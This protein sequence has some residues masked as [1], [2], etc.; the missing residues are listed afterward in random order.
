MHTMKK[1]FTLVELLII[2]VVLVTL[3]SIAFRIGNIGEE[4]ERRTITIQRI[5]R[6]ENALSGY[7]AAFGMYPPVRIHGS[8]NMYLRVDG[9]GLQSDEGEENTSIWGWVDNDDAVTN[10]EREREAWRQVEAACRS[11]PVGC[12]FPF[13]KEYQDLVRASSEE[14]Q[15]WADQSESMPESV[16]RIASMG[17]DDGVTENINRHAQNKTKIEW[18]DI[19]LFKFGVLSYLLPRYLVMMNGDPVFFT[20][21]AQWTGNNVAPSDPLT[22]SGMNWRQVRNYAQG[23]NNSDIMHVANI[24]SQ[25]VCARWMACFE[26][27]LA[28]NVDRT[29]FGVQ[30]RGDDADSL[31][32]WTEN[33]E[34]GW[35]TGQIYNPNGWGS[36]SS[37]NYILDCI[38]MRDG[39]WN[40]LY[41]YSPAPYQSYT[42]WSAGANGRTFP[43]W[44]SREKLPSDAQRCAAYWTKDDI[45]GL[46][47]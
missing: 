11:Q 45:V 20:E 22:G 38:T 27:A 15:M 32:R 4:S 3:M 35:L 23:D 18:Q 30:I 10:K 2:V 5:Q 14:L 21:Y 37:G 40:E 28:C 29:L 44:V 17:F 47:N 36:S 34:S 9:N 7:Y 31:P 8:R 1:G 39:W 19:Q 26:K 13:A 6:M 24:P 25:A 33:G 42:L 43:P 16:K 41:Y 46:K 12:E